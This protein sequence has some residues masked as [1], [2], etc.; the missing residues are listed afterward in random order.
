MTKLTRMRTVK[1]NGLYLSFILSENKDISGSPEQFSTA[2]NKNKFGNES[3]PTNQ[4]NGT[5]KSLFVPLGLGLTN[6]N[7]YL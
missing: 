2:F 6:K 1:K 4:L 7:F 3:R 5:V